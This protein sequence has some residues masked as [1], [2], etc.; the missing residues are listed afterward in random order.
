MSKGYVYVLSNPSMPGLV[1]VGR[2][3]KGGAARGNALYQTGVPTPYVLEFEMYC[4]DHEAI[5][6][7]AHS[8]L[9]LMRTNP[10]REFFTASVNEAASAIMKCYLEWTCDDR[11]VNCLMFEAAVDVFA[12]SHRLNLAPYDV[13]ESIVYLDKESVNS[14]IE[15]A[16]HGRKK[17]TSNLYSLPARKAK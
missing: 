17:P 3:I 7:N 16:F 8:E 2:S 14:A 9:D 15:R 6:Q 4:E 1:K 5:E 12:L 13:V 11:L 10:N